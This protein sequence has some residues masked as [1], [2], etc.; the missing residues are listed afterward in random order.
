MKTM[1]LSD[2]PT[3]IR[4]DLDDKDRVEMTCDWCGKT[5]TFEGTEPINRAIKYAQENHGDCLLK[6]R[7]KIEIQGAA[8]QTGQGRSSHDPHDQHG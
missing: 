5:V 2:L 8:R 7:E 6:S 3:G 1:Q 4:F